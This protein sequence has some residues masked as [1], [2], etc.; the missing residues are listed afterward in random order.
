MAAREM[1]HYT[2]CGLDY[3]WLKNG[4]RVERTSYGPKVVVEHASE[5]DRAI[6]EVVLRRKRHL[7]FSEV[8][9]LR[10][11]LGL[12]RAE[13]AVR[14]GTDAAEVAHWESIDDPVRPDAD[15][16]LRGLVLD[17]LGR[18]AVLPDPESRQQEI[19][20]VATRSDGRWTIAIR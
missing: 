12:S 10:G 18:P 14:L 13:L 19:E 7:A 4:F 3:A 11:L 2:E 8:D 17:H 15:A 1:H 5:L 20:L 6:A 9:F 16:A